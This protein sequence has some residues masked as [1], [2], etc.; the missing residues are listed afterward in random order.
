MTTRDIL[1]PQPSA[2]TYHELYA[3]AKAIY[4]KGGKD[5]YEL[6]LALNRQIR[7]RA[8]HEGHLLWQIFGARFMGLCHHRLAQLDTAIAHFQEAIALAEPLGAG[9]RELVLLIK[10][11]LANTLRQHGQLEEAYTLLR[12]SLRQAPLPEFLHAHG[13]LVGSLGA[14]LDQ[15]GQRGAS[16]DCYARFEVLS[17]LRDNP[18]RLANAVALAARAAELREDFATAEEK[19]EEEAELARRLEDPLRVTSAI[20][21]GA[22]MAWRRNDPDR[23]AHGFKAALERAD[24]HTVK[25]QADALELYAKFLHER[26]D[27][28]TARRHFLRAMEGSQDLEKLASVNHGLAL[29]CRDAGLY[30]ESLVYLSRSVKHRAQLYAPLK[31]LK[32]QVA[33]RWEELKQFTDELVHEAF[34]VARSEEERDTLARLVDSVRG[35]GTWAQSYASEVQRGVGEPIWDYRERLR[36]RSRRIWEQ[37]LLR[38]CFTQFTE[39]SRKLIER[40]EISYS[41]AVD[42]LGRSAH[43]LALVV[44][45][46]LRHRIFE[47]AQQHVGT[48]RGYSKCS[49]THAKFVGITAALKSGDKPHNWTLGDMF[50]SLDELVNPPTALRSDDLLHQ[51]RASLTNHDAAIRRIHTAT[52]EIR[53]LV[54]NPI[55]LLDVRNAVAHG[56]EQPLN[57]LQVDAIKRHLALEAGDGE[58]TILQAVAQVSLR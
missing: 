52:R 2:P 6:S 20:L 22:W 12:D 50:K 49:A 41:S 43:L 24:R 32:P 25:R 45:C 39:H 26:R 7:E 1:T 53:P 56:D 36:E 35:P 5:N 57:R 58:P 11:H 44:E 54:G 48:P 19:Y 34:R 3:E 4:G 51:L 30:G 8:A 31:T 18:H 15:L 38:D 23:A 16:D 13:R 10:N 46:E 9:A 14:L 29:V 17:R 28:I 37:T 55:K 40:A 42:D 47:P 21:H 27:L 33:P